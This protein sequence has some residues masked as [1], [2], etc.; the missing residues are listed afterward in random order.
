MRNVQKIQNR[1]EAKNDEEPVGQCRL[2]QNCFSVLFFGFCFCSLFF[3]FVFF[4]F[5]G[6]H[7]WHMDVPRLGVQSELQLLDYTTATATR[8][9]SRVCNSHH[10]SEQCQIFN[11]LREA[12]DQT[13]VLMGTSQIRFH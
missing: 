13:Y 9:L 6:P 1:C 8:D 12:R 11:T 3:V 10:S 7:A 4:V 5:L 2:R